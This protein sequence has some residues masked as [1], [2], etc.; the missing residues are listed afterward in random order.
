MP[1]PSMMNW[2]FS[3][4]DSSY[5]TYDNQPTVRDYISKYFTVHVESLNILN[6]AV[7]MNILYLETLRIYSCFLDSFIGQVMTIQD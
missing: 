2:C 1:L 5:P 3:P 6:D 4:G 7:V